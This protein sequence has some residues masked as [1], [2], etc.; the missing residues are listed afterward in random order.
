MTP[1]YMGNLHKNQ[2]KKSDRNIVLNVV[3]IGFIVS[4]I[5]TYLIEVNSIS[6]YSFKVDILKNRVQELEINN[7]LLQI[8][9][10][11]L[12]SMSNLD[13]WAERLKLIQVAQADYLISPLT[14]VAA[15]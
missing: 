6:T 4:F 13:F 2:Q 14:A 10:S 15:K 1:F 11:K 3:L 9:L 5:I 12:N 8:E 7:Q